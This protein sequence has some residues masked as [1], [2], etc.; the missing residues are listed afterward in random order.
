M[1]I[2]CLP[3]ILIFCSKSMSKQNRGKPQEM[4]G[5][6]SFLQSVSWPVWPTGLIWPGV[7]F[8]YILLMAAL[9][10]QSQN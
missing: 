7:S 10:P 5:N 8:I 6:E 9:V 4:V 3:P 1:P 2:L